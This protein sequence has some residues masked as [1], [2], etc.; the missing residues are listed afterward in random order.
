M[1]DPKI[2]FMGHSPSN[3]NEEL[4]LGHTLKMIHV[5]A[6][7]IVS[8][9][10]TLENYFTSVEIQKEQFQYF[11][12]L[13]MEGI[14]KGMMHLL[15]TITVRLNDHNTNDRFEAILK[16]YQKY[17]FETDNPYRAIETA[18]H[19]GFNHDA[20]SH[21]I[22]EINTVSQRA[23]DDEGNIFKVPFDMNQIAGSLTGENQSNFSRQNC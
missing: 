13:N 15:R 20:R 4:A 6:N 23:V 5:G 12:S 19:W 11:Q 7:K 17:N 16:S 1:I 10:T 3:K 8:N 18:N 9:A 14:C 2:D 22:K 21:W